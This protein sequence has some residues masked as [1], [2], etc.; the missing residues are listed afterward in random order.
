MGWFSNQIEERRQADQQRLEASFVKVAGVVLGQRIAEKNSDARIITKNAIDE[1]LKAFH[2]APVDPPASV[3]DPEQQLGGPLQAHQLYHLVGCH[4]GQ[5]LNLGKQSAA[6][7]GQLLGQEVDVQ[8][9]VGKVLLYDVV[10]ALQEVVVG[11]VTCYLRQRLQRFAGKGFEQS[12]AHLQRVAD[13][14][15]QI[16]DGEGLFHVSVGTDVHALHLRVVV[17]LGGEH[18]ERYVAGSC[19]LADA[20]AQLGT[21][22]ARHHPVADDEAHLV[23]SQLVESFQSVV[24]RNHGVLLLEVPGQIVEHVLVVVDEKENTLAVEG[25]GLGLMGLIGLIGLMGLIGPIGLIGLIGPIGLISLIGLLHRQHHHKLAALA[26]LALYGNGAAVLADDIADNAQAN[27]RAG[28]VIGSLIERA[29]DALAVFGGY[30]HAIV[31]NLNAE[32]VAARLLIAAHADAAL[33]VLVGIGQQVAHHLGDGLSIDDGREVLVGIVDGELP[34]ILGKRRGKA[35]ADVVH[36][37]TDVVYTEA[38]GHLLLLH[39]AEVQQLVDQ[40]QQTVGVTV[41]DLQVSR[42][43]SLLHQVFQRT[44]D[45]GYRR[46]YFVGYHR[47]EAKTGLA[48]LLLLGLRQPADV[49]LM[50]LL[51]TAQPQADV[52]PDG[53]YN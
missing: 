28:L 53:P 20:A 34:P 8:V 37:L 2:Y 16:L 45:K 43:L 36:Q 49:L 40:L 25:R 51:S 29:E 31:L 23:V 30:A 38:H 13:N 50:A 26:H 5:R 14:A 3:Q 15:L 33:G 12:A 4:V 10:H 52:I 27:A 1:I 35:L 22:H 32:A 39:L 19:I 47:E 42:R 18:D 6:R 41:D 9:R 17:G 48:G 44:D 11:L 21:V 7:D 24:G 46:S